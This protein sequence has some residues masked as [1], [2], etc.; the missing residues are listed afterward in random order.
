MR[1]KITCL[2]KHKRATD[3][4]HSTCRSFDLARL[5]T[6]PQHT[7]PLLP[8]LRSRPGG[9]HKASVVRSP[10]SDNSLEHC[11]MPI[12]NCCLVLC[13]LC[14]VL[15]PYKILKKSDSTHPAHRSSKNQTSGSNRQSAIE[16][17]K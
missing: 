4:S 14:L 1:A 15:L 9:V 2:G 8:L 3:E 10:K 11:Q 16:N 7:Q 12:A 17:R 6:Y 13:T 5:R